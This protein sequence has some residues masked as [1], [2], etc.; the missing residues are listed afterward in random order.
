[1]CIFRNSII[2]YKKYIPLKERRLYFS[3]LKIRSY[4]KI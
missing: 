3:T 4:N 2:F 1:M